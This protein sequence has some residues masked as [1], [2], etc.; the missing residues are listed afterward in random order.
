MI[1][2]NEMRDRMSSHGVV[3]AISERMIREINKDLDNLWENPSVGLSGVSK[4]FYLQPDL[5]EEDREAVLDYTCRFYEELGFKTE[6]QEGRIESHK[7]V[8]LSW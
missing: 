5:Q 8:K 3:H 1:F 2:A 7:F 6:V 4:G